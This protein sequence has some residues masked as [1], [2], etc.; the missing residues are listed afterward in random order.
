M[1]LGRDPGADM[2]DDVLRLVCLVHVPIPPDSQFTLG[3]LR[4]AVVKID[5][6]LLQQ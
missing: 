3:V 5:Q 6:E 1:R 2:V 4:V